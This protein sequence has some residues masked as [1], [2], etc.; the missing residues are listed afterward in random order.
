ME[1]YTKL[2]KFFAKAMDYTLIAGDAMRAYPYVIDK[3]GDKEI[4]NLS[5][6]HCRSFIVGQQGDRKYIVSKG[7]GLA[8]SSYTFLYTPEMP[9]DVWGLLRKEDALRDFYCG[10]DVQALGIKANQME[11]VIELD[12]PIFIPQT[13]E[14]LNPCLLQYNVECPWRIADAGFMTQ[15]QIWDEVTKWERLNDKAFQVEYLIAANVLIRNLR[16]LHDNGVLHNALTYENI[17]WALELLD[18]ELCHTPQHPYGKEDYVRHVP[19][20]F[21]REIIDTYKLINYIAGVLRQPVDY[22]RVDS[23]FLEYGFDIE[24][25]KV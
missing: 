22:K 21:D 12:H 2:N 5:P 25:F 6:I 8:Y 14:T 11:C 18:F 13:K 20:L 1:D 17:T 24:N 7:N 15:D 9:T 3:R 16:T 4:Y 10:Q 23:L 19:V